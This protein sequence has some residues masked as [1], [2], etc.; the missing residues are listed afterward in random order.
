MWTYFSLY[1]GYELYIYKPKSQI[2]SCKMKII[3]YFVAYEMKYIFLCILAVYMY[4]YTY[5]NI[6]IKN[7][8]VLCYKKVLHYIYICTYI[9]THVLYVWNT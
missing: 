1:I 3:Y 6:I 8:K 5:D 9:D 2:I 7:K 4:N